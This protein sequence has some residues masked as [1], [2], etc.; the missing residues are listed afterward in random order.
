MTG[1]IDGVLCVHNAF[2][3]DMLQIDQEAYKLVGSEGDIS[4]ILDRLHIMGE[5]LDFHARGE[6]EAVF[7]AVD[8]SVPL[9]TK[10][11]IM[12]HR[13][14]DRLVSGLE[15]LRH[16]PDNLTAARETAALNQHLRLHLDKEDAF[17]YPLLREHLSMPAQFSMIGHMS[18]S[19]PAEKSPMFVQWMFPLINLEERV[20]MAGIWKVL[21]PPDIFEMHKSLIRKAIPSPEWDEL[22]RRSP[23]LKQ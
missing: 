2:R 11:Y 12:D 14:L 6:E 19:I 3:R 4:Q 16:G 20:I 17:L 10:T 1:P 22:V 18:G 21:M 7:P 9:L 8:D 5:I 13:E 15:L 23:D